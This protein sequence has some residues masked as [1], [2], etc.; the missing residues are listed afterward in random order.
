MAGLLTAGSGA[1]CAADAGGAAP[2]AW[3]PSASGR[4]VVAGP[5][6]SAARAMGRQVEDAARRVE[7]FLGWGLAKQEEPLCRIV[8]H[9]AP[10]WR[11]G[12]A[13]LYRDAGGFSLDVVGAERIEEEDLAEALC[14]VLVGCYAIQARRAGTEPE[15]ARTRVDWLAAG[16]AHMAYPDLKARARSAAAA[17]KAD[18]ELPSLAQVFRWERLPDGPMIQKAVC[19]QVV[20]WLW[21]LPDRVVVF[22]AMFK[23]LGSGQ[24]VTVDWLTA[25]EGAA[26]E[27]RDAEGAWAAFAGQPRAILSGYRPVTP[28]LLDLLRT[29]LQIDGAELGPDGAGLGRLSPYQALALRKAPGMREAAADR[30]AELRVLVVGTPG[31]FGALVERFAAIYDAIPGWVPSGV[32]HSR[33]K[34]ASAALEELARTT[35][36]RRAYVDEVERRVTGAGA[37]ATEAGENPFFGRTPYS[38]YVD[39]VERRMGDAERS[40]SGEHEWPRE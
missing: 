33:L 27:L 19:G 40:A 5:T 6:E 12:R 34:S 13:Y 39:E 9:P 26:V 2:A 25:A 4:F 22:R 21:N 7:G 23:Q 35:D 3:I 16:L 38:A 24:S 17:L 36:E 37:D 31:E 10:E 11:S 28:G 14:R 30:A 29:T 15:S 20:A 18:G 1:L 32:L 8:V